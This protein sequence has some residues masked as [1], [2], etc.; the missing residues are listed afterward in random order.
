MRRWFAA[1][2]VVLA[3]V[4]SAASGMPAA[5]TASLPVQPPS[6]TPMPGIPE[7]CVSKSAWPTGLAP[8]TTAER[9]QEK[10]GV[11]LMGQ[12]WTDY[13]YRP[14]VKVVWQTLDAV[15]CTDYVTTIKARNHGVLVL[16]AAPI[17]GWAWGDWSLTQPGALT[18]DFSKWTAALDEGDI[19]RLVRLLIHEM[20]HAYTVNRFSQPP[21][22]N[23]FAELYAR[24]GRFSSYGT[25]LEETFSDV[26][27]Y[28]VGRCAKD[29]PFDKPGFAAYYAYAREVV[30][31]GVEFGSEPGEP[32]HCETPEAPS[33]TSSPATP[34]TAPRGFR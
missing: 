33:A 22:W 26:L 18:L 1:L 19:G 27:G 25:N 23:Q 20:G 4:I 13:H 28:Y 10:F 14:L 34:W 8:E 15:S 32:L 2:V 16:N 17:S 9:L 6:P 31:N 24:E 30:F 3:G 21:Y 7:P 12:W 5:G 11:V 29:N